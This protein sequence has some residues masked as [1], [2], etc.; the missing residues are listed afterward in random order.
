MQNN[1][2]VWVALVVVA[3]IAIG[4]YAFPKAVDNFGGTRYANGLSADSTLP[5]AG[6]VRGSTLT[7]TGAATIGGLIQFDGGVLDSTTNS[8]S[9]TATAYTMAAADLIGYKSILM[10]SNTGTT[11]FTFASTSLSTWIPAV[12]DRQQFSWGVASTSAGAIFAGSTGVD[13][14]GASST[15]RTDLTVDSD[16]IAEF[17]AVRKANASG[18]VGDIWLIL[19]ESANAD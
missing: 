15:S 10:T 13:I 4:A 19:R 6:Q 2:N 14:E 3:I 1:K 9:T 8:T 18:G 7:I 17:T 11:T 16:S 5:V 12:G